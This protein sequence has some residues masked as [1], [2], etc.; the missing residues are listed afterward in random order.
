MDANISDLIGNDLESD[1]E[2]VYEEF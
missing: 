1:V 2:F